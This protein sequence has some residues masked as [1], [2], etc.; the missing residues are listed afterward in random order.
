[1]AFFMKL[2]GQTWVWFYRLT[3]NIFYFLI[4]HLLLSDK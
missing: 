1:M 2:S 4:I 3:D